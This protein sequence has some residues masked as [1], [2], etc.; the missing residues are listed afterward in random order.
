MNKFSTFILLICIGFTFTSCLEVATQI[1]SWN[2]LQEN[3][4]PKGRFEFL[5]DSGVKVYIPVEFE[6]ISIFEYQKIIKENLTEESQTLEINRMNKL[7]DFDGELYL[8]YDSITKASITV[9]TI[10]FM[11]LTREE[12]RYLLGLMRQQIN[13][14][15]ANLPLDIEKISSQYKGNKNDYIFKY[16]YKFTNTEEG[17]AVY[18][19]A[20]FITKDFQ[21]VFI[22]LNAGFNAYYDP[23]AVKTI[24]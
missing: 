5:E 24:M 12:A 7:K 4:E 19:S 17:F 22:N 21:T 13:E 18:N 2:D 15:T 23:F 3:D 9:N 14:N 1:S 20:Y 6:R 10:P 16:I 11:P 8:F